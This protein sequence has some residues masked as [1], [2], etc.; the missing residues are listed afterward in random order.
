MWPFSMGRWSS[1]LHADGDYLFSNRQREDVMRRN[2]M[3][4]TAMVA[5]SSILLVSHAK[6]EQRFHATLS[7]FE[8][9]GS[10]TNLTGAIF[11]PG[12][13]TLDLTINDQGTQITYTLTYSGLTNTVTQSHTHFGKEHVAGGVMVFFCSNLGNGPIGT[14]ACPTSGTVTSQLTPGSVV[15]PAGQGIAPG[16][17]AAVIAAIQSNTAYA[18]VHTNI[19]PSGE[20]RGQIRR[21]EDDNVTRR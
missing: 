10:L 15:G 19:F 6:A 13:G 21:R 16:N 2:I 1:A 9:L 12:A 14:P 18:N 17:F 20:I 7:G 4:W 11:S 3:A 8:E 5:A